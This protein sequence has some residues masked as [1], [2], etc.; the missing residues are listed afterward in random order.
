MFAP[1]GYPRYVAE[2]ERELDVEFMPGCL[3]S[4]R[5]DVAA[6]VRF[7][8]SLTG[9]ALAED[10]DF[11][12][13]L[14]REGRIRYVPQAVL[15]HRKSGFAAADAR[16]FGRRVIVNRVY[17]FR[18]NFDPTP[19]K[20]AQFGFLFL[21]LFGHRLVNRNWAGA[22]GLLDGVVEACRDRPT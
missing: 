19:W 8:E 13:R 3:M 6:R 20:W 1:F 9:Y 17:L 7:D 11:S 5:R 22:R 10:E 4:A 21:L 16:D 15:E 18:K 14:S 12:Y 2:P